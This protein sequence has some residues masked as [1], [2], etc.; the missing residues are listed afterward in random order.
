MLIQSFRAQNRRFRPG[1]LTSECHCRIICNDDQINHVIRAEA[2]SPERRKMANKRMFSKE[3]T[4]TDRFQS[5]KLSAQ[6]LY[7]HL[8]VN[9][10]DDGFI[11]NPMS[12][13]RSIGAASS[14]LKLLVD[15]GYLIPFGGGVYLIT[16]WL[17]NNHI[18]KDRYKPTI[19]QEFF[20]MICTNDVQRY[21]VCQPSG[22]PVV[23]TDKSSVDK[24]S[25]GK[26]SIED[27]APSRR[28]RPPTT[29]DVKSY[30]LENGFLI[31]PQKFIDYYESNGWKVGRNHMKDWRAAVRT[32]ARNER[33]K[34]SNTVG[35]DFSAWAS[36]LSEGG[37]LS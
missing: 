19:Y 6:A 11:G 30:C 29:S 36:E 33:P 17:I 25:I 3:V 28:F 34:A 15:S 7:F 1:R 26:S 23:D 35:T 16:D 13:T 14:D 10:D 18:R 27:D 12:I 37:I 8:G 24:S 31:D 32:W 22:I 20:G 5:L 2:N 9:A 4:N 21:V